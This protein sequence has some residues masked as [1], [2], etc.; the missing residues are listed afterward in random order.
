M[1]SMVPHKIQHH[2]YRSILYIFRTLED[3]GSWLHLSTMGNM[4]KV[5]RLFNTSTSSRTA[6]N[7]QGFVP[8]VLSNR[9]IKS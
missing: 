8:T 1:L 4:L 5:S 6:A 7:Y 9:A 3:V 2:G